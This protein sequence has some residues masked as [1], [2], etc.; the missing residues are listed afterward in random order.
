MCLVYLECVKIEGAR[1]DGCSNY[2]AN[3]GIWLMRGMRL[4]AY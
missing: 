2:L 4:C 1:E 3:D